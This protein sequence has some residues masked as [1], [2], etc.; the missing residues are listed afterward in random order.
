MRSAITMNTLVEFW[1]KCKISSVCPYFHPE[2][3]LELFKKNGALVFQ[4]KVKSYKDYTACPEF[5]YF[6]SSK[7][8]LPLVPVPYGGNL[9]K[10]DIIIL[11]LN[12]GL[13]CIDYYGELECAAYRQALEY[14][15]RQDFSKTEFPFIWLNPDFCW[16]SGF[17]WWERKLRGILKTIATEKHDGSYLKALHDLSCRI[18]MIELIPYHSA[19]FNDHRLIDRLP[20]TQQAIKYVRDVL[21]PDA[22][23]GKKLIIVARQNKGWKI[24]KS[25]SQI[26]IYKDSEVR[27]ASLSPQSR[28]GQAILSEYGL[29]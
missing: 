5:L 22:E 3:E 12:P 18:A 11:L 27:N 8:H 13:S 19:K 14:N 20:S 15:L 21:L 24:E 16:Q 26:I 9:K 4:D 23:S 29:L 2:D 7:F 6:E 1:K 17:I 28:G 25:S 10:A